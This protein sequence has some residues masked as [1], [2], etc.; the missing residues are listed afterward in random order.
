MH[1]YSRHIR[2]GDEDYEE[3]IAGWR[4]K[5]L[6]VPEERDALASETLHVMIERDRAGALRGYWLFQPHAH[7]LPGPVRGQA[8]AHEPAP[9]SAGPPWRSMDT[10]GHVTDARR[11]EP[12]CS[13]P[14]WRCSVQGDP[15]RAAARPR[16]VPRPALGLCGRPVLDSTPAPQGYP[17]DFTAILQI[18]NSNTQIA[19]GRRVQIASCHRTGHGWWPWG[20][21]IS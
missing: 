2:T 3:L 17:L 21:C 15:K 9:G 19:C 16:F 1:R 8:R 18:E 5:A 20:R 10:Q 12:G 13:F 6:P 14:L 7:D 4:E 11:A